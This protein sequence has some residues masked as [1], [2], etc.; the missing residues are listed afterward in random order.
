MYLFPRRIIKSPL[1]KSRAFNLAI[2]S[3]RFAESVEDHSFPCKRRFLPSNS[4]LESTYRCVPFSELVVPSDADF[5]SDSQRGPRALAT[6][7]ASRL[8]RSV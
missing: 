8:L 1:R 3:Y 5:P 6:S 2:K 7:L 4:T